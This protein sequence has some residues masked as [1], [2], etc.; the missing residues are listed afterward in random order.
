MTSDLALD[1]C[2]KRCLF[3]DATG[4]LAAFERCDVAAAFRLRP[5]FTATRWSSISSPF[6]H[7]SAARSAVAR[8]LK[9]TNAHLSHRQSMMI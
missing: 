3:Y 6:A 8:S 7:A 9:L 5:H 1:E 4:G 2:R